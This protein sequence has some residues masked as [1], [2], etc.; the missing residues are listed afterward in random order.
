MKKSELVA[1]TMYAYARGRDVPRPVRL[2]DLRLWKHYTRYKQTSPEGWKDVT[3]VRGER[4][5]SS[6]GWGPSYE[7]G[8]FV[9]RSNWL[10]QITAEE[11]A[12]VELPPLPEDSS[13]AAEVIAGLNLPEGIEVA[14]VLPAQ[15][16]QP[17]AEYA[18]EK[19]K[20]DAEEAEARRAQE[21]K[22]AEHD[23]KAGAVEA[24]MDELGVAYRRLTTAA[25]LRSDEPVYRLTATELAKLLDLAE[26]LGLRNVEERR[27]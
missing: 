21:R 8:Y 6:S 26:G 13:K 11:L 3:G 19:A 9:L 1:G 17:W 18:E 20:R 4:P 22:T 24:R 23:A 7:T 25:N 27:S 16:K 10:A 2:L 15:I 5:G 14:L 12:A